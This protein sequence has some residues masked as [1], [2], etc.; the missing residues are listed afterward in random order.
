MLN[1]FCVVVPVIHIVGTF[2]IP[3]SPYFL[4]SMNKIDEAEMSLMK[5]RGDD[6][7]LQ[8]LAVLKVG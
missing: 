8:E 2:F 6:N 7:V 4:L 5:L 1:A 3:E